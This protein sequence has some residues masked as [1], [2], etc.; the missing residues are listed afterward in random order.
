MGTV[1]GT[2]TNPSLQ[3]GVHRCWQHVREPLFSDDPETDFQTQDKS[4]LMKDA[5][6]II[7][8]NIRSQ[9]NERRMEYLQNLR[10]TDIVPFMKDF[11]NNRCEDVVDQTECER[12]ALSTLNVWRRTNS[13]APIQG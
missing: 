11:L 2:T 4:L 10:P 6:R 12:L 7:T 13:M 1:L 3:N 9:P 8:Q 5:H